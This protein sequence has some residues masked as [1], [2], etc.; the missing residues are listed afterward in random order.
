MQFLD[1]ACKE[2]SR[3]I[4][5]LLQELTSIA[6]YYHFNLTTFLRAAEGYLGSNGKKSNV[7]D[8]HPAF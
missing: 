2:I 4:G 3:A 6:F 8:P 1:S 7:V 5:N